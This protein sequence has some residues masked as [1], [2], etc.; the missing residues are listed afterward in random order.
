MQYYILKEINSV[1]KIEDGKAYLYDKEKANW[2]F[3]NANFLRSRVSH[4]QGDTAQHPA[5]NNPIPSLAQQVSEDEA[6]K[7]INMRL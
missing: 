1:G 5:D 7:Y 4:Y 3:D 2:Q 6:Q